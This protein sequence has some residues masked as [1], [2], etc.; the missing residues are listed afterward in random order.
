[1]RERDLGAQ[2]QQAAAVVQDLVAQL[3]VL[4]DD[5]ALLGRQRAGI[6]QDRI[7][8]A[9]VA[10]VVQLGSVVQLARLVLVPADGRGPAAR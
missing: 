4:L 2:V 9:D 3:R 6:E 10:D 8:N 1:V 5:A 7:G